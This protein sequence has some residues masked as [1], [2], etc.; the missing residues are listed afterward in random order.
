MKK[1]LLAL[2]LTVSVML[3]GCNDGGTDSQNTKEE[4][5]VELAATIEIVKESETV[6]KEVSFEEGEALMDIAKSNFEVQE[7][8]GFIN[9]IDGMTA[10]AENKEFISIYVNDEMASKG[11]NDLVSN[12]GDK[13]S[14]KLETW[15]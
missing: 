5:K 9:G 15:E 11:A 12:D 1:V 10:N 8:D 4:Q 13:V 3:V 6:S 7:K 2:F 14:F